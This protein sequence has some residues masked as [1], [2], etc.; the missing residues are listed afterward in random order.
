MRSSRS[1]LPSPCAAETG[2]GS[3]RPS[4]W[5]SPASGMSA[6]TSDLFAATSTG[7][8]LRRRRSA[9]SSSPGRSPPLTSTTS[10]A[11]CASDNAAV[12]WSRIEP[13]IGSGSSR[14]M[15][16][17]STSVNLRPFHS[18]SSSLRSRVT[19][20][21]SSTTASRE[22]LSRLTSELLPTF[23]YP[24]IA[25]RGRLIGSGPP[26]AAWPT[27]RFRRSLRLR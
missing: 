24:T 19:P 17:V 4:R 10:T 3:P 8:P 6:R 23:G 13:A 7:K 12:A 22:P 14:S 25:T 5:N 20:A 15:P 9:I 11:S 21:R 18:Q 27:R 1:P 16:P 2:I 26:S